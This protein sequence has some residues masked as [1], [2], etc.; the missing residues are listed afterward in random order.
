MDKCL[1]LLDLTG[2]ESGIVIYV[3]EGETGPVAL[4]DTWGEEAGVPFMAKEFSTPLYFDREANEPVEVERGVIIDDLMASA[5]MVY[6]PL[7]ETPLA[8]GTVA[9][10]YRFEDGTLVLAPEGWC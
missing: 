7:E 10:V 2:Q 5:R 3:P 8:T 9:D 4:I 1:K 6:D